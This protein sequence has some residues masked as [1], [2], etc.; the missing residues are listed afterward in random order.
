M[1]ASLATSLGLLC[2]RNL[3]D[4]GDGSLAE[5]V[6]ES[7]PADR[8][9]WRASLAPLKDRAFRR[10][11]AAFFVFTFGNLLYLG[12]VAPFFG[13]DLRYGYVEATLLMH[14]LP[15]LTGF[16]AGGRLTA[17]FDRT[18]VFRAYAVVALL[19]GLDPVPLAISPWH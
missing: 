3:P 5:A 7:G 6:S 19:W 15:A 16:L 9:W 11:L 13:R 17:W 18:T 8:S 14:V 1:V 4:R 2:L 10:F 12:V